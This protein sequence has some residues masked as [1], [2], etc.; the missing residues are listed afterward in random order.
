V[1]ITYADI[2]KAQRLLGYSPRVPFSEGID[3]F[4]AWFA[5]HDHAT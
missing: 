3:A 5:S 4:V 1:P 2:A